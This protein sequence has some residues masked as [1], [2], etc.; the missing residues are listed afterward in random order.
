MWLQQFAGEKTEQATPKRREEA[1][2][3]GQ[4][5]K[6]PDLTTALILL[7]V[8]LAI[9]ISGPGSYQVMADY[10]RQTLSS[11]PQGDWR[12]EDV[13]NLFNGMVSVSVQAALPIALTA[14]MVGLIVDTA[15]VG[16][17]FT[18]SGL[19]MDFGRINPAHGL[20][21]MFSRKALIDLLKAMVKAGLVG[22]IIYSSSLR[23]YDQLQVLAGM[24]LS[25]AFALVG[26]ITMGALWKVGLVLLVL[27]GFDYWFQRAE[28]ERSL[29]M[30]KQEI[31]EE[32]KS[33]E[34][35]PAVRARIRERQRA[36]ARQ[37]M[38]QQVPKADVV[39]TNPIHYAVALKY[40]AGKMEAPEVLA[41]GQG[42]IAQ[43]IKEIAMAHGVEVIENRPLA[44][45]LFKSVEAGETI[46]GE[47]YQA[48]AEVLAF[49]YKLK[50]KAQ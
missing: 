20:K 33:T 41:K 6:S 43:K 36:M 1:R 32:T 3:K 16:F 24:D 9:K 18:M 5:A 30:S 35:D 37:R 19:S 42:Y 34:G 29:M 27:A 45:A 7:G 39:V 40:E 22:W 44:Q 38:M 21:R 28:F 31:K 49:V 8:F 46:P 48:V 13:S 15:Q 47:L 12:I 23:D 10:T 14:L 26:G 25:E 2:K 50:K 4:V 17:N 11:F